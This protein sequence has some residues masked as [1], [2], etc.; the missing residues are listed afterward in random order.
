MLVTILGEV[1]NGTDDRPPVVSLSARRRRPWD[2]AADLCEQIGAADLRARAQSPIVERASDALRQA[3]QRS[4]AV[5]EVAD[6]HWG[7]RE[8]A[9]AL[10]FAELLFSACDGG[11]PR[12]TVLLRG[13]P[14]PTF[15]ARLALL[16]P[17]SYL[18]VDVDR[19]GIG[20]PI[21]DPRTADAPIVDEDEDEDEGDEYDGN[22]EDARLWFERGE[23]LRAEGC[24]GEL[25]VLVP[26]TVGRTAQAVGA[27][28]A[29]GD[30]LLLV[31]ALLEGGRPRD[32]MH[33]L[34]DA[35]GASC[36]PAEAR[37]VAALRATC[38]LQLGDF[39]TA[40]SVLLEAAAGSAAAQLTAPMLLDVAVKRLELLGRLSDAL[41]LA[42]GSALRP[43]TRRESYVF[44]VE[45]CDLLFGLSNR[46]AA[47]DAMA[48]A[49]RYLSGEADEE[50]AAQES[51][52]RGTVVLRL[53]AG[54][55]DAG[56]RLI[57]QQGRCCAAVARVFTCLALCHHELFNFTG[58]LHFL[59]CALDIHRTL[60]GEGT[61]HPRV[62]N[63]LLRCGQAERLL[64]HYE[65]A[66]EYFSAALAMQ[67]RMHV[68]AHLSLVHPLHVTSALYSDLGRNREAVEL[69]RRALD[70]LYAVLGR[71]ALHPDIATNLSNTAFA[72]RALD[73][74]QE[75][76]ALQRDALE[77]RRRLFPGD[78][79]DVA[80]SLG[81]LA[82]SLRD[83][84]AYTE[85]LENYKLALAMKMRLHASDVSIAATYC[86]LA[87]VYSSQQRYSDALH[88]HRCDL[89]LSLAALGSD[90]PDV[91]TS[92][93]NVGDTLRLMQRYADA[94]PRLSRALE[95]RE[96]HLG[97]AHILYASTCF[98]LGLVEGRLG[99]HSRSHELFETASRVATAAVGPDHPRA[100][101]YN[102]HLNN[103]RNN[104]P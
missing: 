61:D 100:I 44:D 65:R 16:P 14:T 48:R 102:N 11:A 42:D 55:H 47:Y 97:V 71:D 13:R 43:L 46:P 10:P 62:A 87:T 96:R 79:T 99:H 93:H 81:S 60:V 57:A 72:L 45:R 25:A 73:Q 83:I 104:L 20:S 52:G 50:L 19:T 8:N 94:A 69:L 17:S 6:A 103:V 9:S 80:A 90:H 12:A 84:S 56:R 58:E 37:R 95:I 32:A 76:L 86:N 89:A 70:V 64:P 63:A 92:L 49:F 24:T 41:A 33:A 3:L 98:S 77:M 51:D 26:L 18:R 82:A 15:R 21:A 27:A 101:R 38:A 36:G 59:N 29:L 68:G 28:V 91:A 34:T 75:A 78:H 5:V 74:K 66:A 31:S 1:Q 85:A 39:A 30:P 54:L 23:L 2:L 22:D 7:V 53:V 4:R 35:A 88:Y 67:E 40:E